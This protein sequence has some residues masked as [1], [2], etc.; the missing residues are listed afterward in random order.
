MVEESVTPVGV[1]KFAVYEC[2][3]CT[4]LSTFVFVSVILKI[5]LISN[6]VETKLHDLP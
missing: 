4:L 1:S 3:R 2:D 6:F 5:V